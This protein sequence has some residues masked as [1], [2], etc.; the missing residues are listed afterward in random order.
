MTKRTTNQNL[1]LVYTQNHTTVTSP[2]K[3]WNQIRCRI[4]AFLSN[5]SFNH[6]SNSTTIW[7]NWLIIIHR[8]NKIEKLLII[9]YLISFFFTFLFFFSLS[10][11]WCRNESGVLNSSST[12]TGSITHWQYS[13]TSDN[14][15]LP[16]SALAYYYISIPTWGVGIHCSLDH[17]G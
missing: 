10:L 5:L 14:V 4:R 6:I 12:S 8:L 9:L 17:H 7:W 1:K 3:S 16:L 2:G 11:N 15:L 13:L